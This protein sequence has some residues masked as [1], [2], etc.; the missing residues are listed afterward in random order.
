MR[1]RGGRGDHEDW[2][3]DL[4]AD[5]WN[6]LRTLGCTMVNTRRDLPAALDR[7]PHARPHMRLHARTFEVSGVLESNES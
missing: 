1:T 3:R 5:S 7:K 6:R 4:T 2:D